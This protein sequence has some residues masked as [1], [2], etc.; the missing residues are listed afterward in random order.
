MSTFLRYIAAAMV[1]PELA[2]DDCPFLWEGGLTRGSSGRQ[3]LPRTVTM[4]AAN[5]SKVGCKPAWRRINKNSHWS[6][7]CP[8]QTYRDGI[9]KAD[10]FLVILDVGNVRVNV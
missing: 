5:D 9:L 3:F 7:E 4:A 1:S 6:L 8:K 2:G 10:Y